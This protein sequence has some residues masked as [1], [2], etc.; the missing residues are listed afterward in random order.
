MT[1]FTAAGQLSVADMSAAADAAT[2][3]AGR[4]NALS[5]ALSIAAVYGISVFRTAA[6]ELRFI[7]L[8]AGG[9]THITT[10]KFTATGNVT[11]ADFAL[12]DSDGRIAE[13]ARI[14]ARESRKRQTLTAWLLAAGRAA[15]AAESAAELSAAEPAAASVPV[16]AAEP[17]AEDVLSAAEAAAYDAA[18]QPAPAT[19]AAAGDA[20][21]AVVAEYRH[22]ALGCYGYAASVPVVAAEPAADA[23]PPLAAAILA[24]NDA[25]RRYDALATAGEAAMPEARALASAQ[26][27][28]IRRRIDTD[29]DDAAQY[30][31]EAYEAADASARAAGAL[32]AL[33]RDAADAGQH[34]LAEALDA[35]ATPVAEKLAADYRYVD[36]MREDMAIAYAQQSLAAEWTVC[37]DCLRGALR[38][39][40]QNLATLPRR[41]GESHDGV[42]RALSVAA[43]LA[44]TAVRYI[45]IGEDHT[46][47]DSRCR[48]HDGAPYREVAHEFVATM[49]AQGWADKSRGT[50]GAPGWFAY[51]SVT[52]AELTDVAT[53]F[54]AETA[55]IGA[56]LSARDILGYWVVRVLADG[57]QDAFHTDDAADAQSYY[58]ELLTDALG[59]P[60]VL[61]YFHPEASR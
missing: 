27:A 15:A 55:H 8:T 19:L 30:L 29:A 57:R 24:A 5:S 4:S 52:A 44:E 53:C 60:E 10:A 33:R 39:A 28:A 25:E 35:A 21:A 43:T 51:V 31:S 45:A 3:L 20:L 32:S 9:D 12:A 7:L 22:A 59:T 16:V 18:S 34:A 54:A 61:G 42:H 50:A 41:V 1:K 47:A 56:E 48:A 6:G 37:E 49:A 36:A 40:A 11:S 14:T 38:S 17:A 26:L 23:L 13:S 58:R 46:A 2:D